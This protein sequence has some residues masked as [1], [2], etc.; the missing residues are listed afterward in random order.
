MWIIIFLSAQAVVSKPGMPKS[1]LDC[2]YFYFV[3]FS[4]IGYGDIVG[5]GATSSFFGLV[6][7]FG[8]SIISGVV[9]SF[10]KLTENVEIRVT[11]GGISCRYT[12][13]EK[14]GNIDGQ[15]EQAIDDVAV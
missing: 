13:E 12:D 4:T 7:F 10:V 2:F 6:L 14:N 11:C 1:W 5:P 3:A 9:D 15:L 8:L